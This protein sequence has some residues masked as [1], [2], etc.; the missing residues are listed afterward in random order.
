MP[1]PNFFIVGAT[2][3]GTTSLYEYLNQTPGVFMSSIKEPSF[4]SVSINRRRPVQNE[5]EYL[6]LFEDAKP[7]QAIGEATTRYI[8]DPKSAP[9]IKNK[10][11][12]AKIIILLRDPVERAYSSYL[13]YLRR[14]NREP[15]SVIMKRS[16]ETDL[17]GDYLLCLVMKGGLYYEQVK[18]YLDTFG[19][20]SVKILFYEEFFADIKNQFNELLKFLGVEGK[21]P[22][23]I[24]TVFN[25]SKKPRNKISKFILDFDDLIWKA[26]IKSIF[27]FFPKRK[28]LEERFL[29]PVNESQISEKDK[30]ELISFYQE[31]IK[32]LKALLQRD[33]PWKNFD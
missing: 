26:G 29:E 14:E 24:N 5:D 1:W 7:S 6:K 18:R 10:I 13:Y 27:P 28:N 12:N 19:H 33:L 15:F 16:I 9:L 31:D 30:L 32:K 8:I 20:D 21:L 4:F 22:E 17:A 25:E 11:P 3:C 23:I 2:R